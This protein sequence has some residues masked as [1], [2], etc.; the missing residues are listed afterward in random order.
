MVETPK[1]AVAQGPVSVDVV[2]TNFDWV[3]ESIS[4]G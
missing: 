2:V 4:G 3:C 1:L